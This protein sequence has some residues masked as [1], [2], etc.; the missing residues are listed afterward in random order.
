MLLHRLGRGTQRE[1][2]G[3]QQPLTA[4]VPFGADLHPLHPSGVAHSSHVLPGLNRLESMTLPRNACGCD[5]SQRNRSPDV[6]DRPR[7]AFGHVRVVL[8]YLVHL[9]VLDVNVRPHLCP[10]IGEVPRR[11]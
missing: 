7:I 4:Q 1:E 3:E 8:T 9:Q 5:Q 6:S 2:G 11:R 10:P